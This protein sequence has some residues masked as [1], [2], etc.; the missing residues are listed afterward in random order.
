MKL[1]WNGFWRLP[2]R[3]SSVE[4]GSGPGLTGKRPASRLTV[5]LIR[6]QLEIFIFFKLLN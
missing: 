1:V 4:P 3:K 2:A 5:E 6:E